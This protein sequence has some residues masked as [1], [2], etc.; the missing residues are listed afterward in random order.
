MSK[1]LKDKIV[2]KTKSQNL[3]SLAKTSESEQNNKDDG[4][5]D[6]DPSESDSSD[7]EDDKKSDQE[8]D[9]YDKHSRK[10]IKSSSSHITVIT[11]N[12]QSFTLKHVNSKSLEDFEEYVRDHKR[13]LKK[14][15]NLKDYM[16]SSAIQTVAFYLDGV[17]ID[18]AGIEELYSRHD[19]FFLVL[20]KRYIN[21]IFINFHSY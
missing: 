6:K 4:N 14:K 11:D 2:Q 21:D 17:N 13:Q 9:D 16:N 20:K 8:D 12:K 19:D 5:S 3:E 15:I 10:R 1:E 18:E 7:D